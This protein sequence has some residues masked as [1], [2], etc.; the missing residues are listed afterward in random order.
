MAKQNYSS[1]QKGIIDR[2]YENMDTIALQSL[3]ELV[4]EIYLAE[5]DRKLDRLWERVEKSLAKLNVPAA[6]ANHILEKRDPAILA[7]N[8]TE[9]LANSKKR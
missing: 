8:L 2:Y 6:V 1:Y 7:K 4:S 9:W 3:Q 5:T